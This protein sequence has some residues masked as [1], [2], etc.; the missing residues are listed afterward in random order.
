MRCDH[1][2]HGIVNNGVV[3]VKCGSALCGHR[4]GVVV[5]HK[6]DGITGELITTALYKD[7]PKINSKEGQVNGRRKRSTSVRHP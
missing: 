4:P 6:F 7:T 5:I 2:L 1:K 3:E